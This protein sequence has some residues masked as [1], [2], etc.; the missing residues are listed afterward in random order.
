MCIRD[1]L[2]TAE[3]VRLNRSENKKME[4]TNVWARSR[5]KA[6]HEVVEVQSRLLGMLEQ[7]Q[8]I[9]Q[10]QLETYRELRAENELRFATLGQSE[11]QAIN[12]EAQLKLTEIVKKRLEYEERIDLLKEKGKQL[13]CLLY[14]SPSPRDRQKSRMP[15]SA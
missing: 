2:F 15:F 1:R 9:V 14:T 4:E 6:V 11:T 10:D 3:R 13:S 5:A 8:D 7:E 12:T